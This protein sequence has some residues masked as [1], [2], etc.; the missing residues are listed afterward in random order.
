MWKPKTG[1]PILILKQYYTALE[2]AA[3]V[4]PRQGAQGST[5]SEPSTLARF[6]EEHVLGIIT[7][8][9]HVINDFKV[10][11]PVPE[12]K[13]NIIAMSEMMA[14]ARGNISVALPQVCFD[15]YSKEVHCI[16][17]II[18]S[19]LAFGLPLM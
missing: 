19:A 14:I 2:L 4:T 3:S 6:V 15:F 5:Q 17:E 9:A 1:R 7:E 8:F 16:N 10:L 13:R 18:R 11:Q 12:K